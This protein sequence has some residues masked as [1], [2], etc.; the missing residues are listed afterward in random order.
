M[1]KQK[2]DNDI[3]GLAL[4]SVLGLVLVLGLGLGLVLGLALGLALV[5]VLGLALILGSVLVSVLGLVLA[6]GLDDR[7]LKY[8][9]TGVMIGAIIG[10]IIIATNP[11]LAT[12]NQI[13]TTTTI[14]PLNLNCTQLSN[15]INGNITQGNQ[16]AAQTYI[17]LAQ[18]RGCLGGK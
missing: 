1:S 2:E 6:L 11:S 4:V 12:Q 8:Y 5:S 16:Q 13:T 7:E 14:Q 10:L 18:A 15:Y 17:Q 9:S 3:S